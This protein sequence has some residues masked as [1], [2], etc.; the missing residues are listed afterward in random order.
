M[1]SNRYVSK[2]KSNPQVQILGPS[3]PPKK[4]VYFLHPNL[5]VCQDNVVKKHMMHNINVAKLQ[6]NISPTW[7]SLK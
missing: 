5:G 4:S 2:T 1:S 7:I 3:G 6:Y